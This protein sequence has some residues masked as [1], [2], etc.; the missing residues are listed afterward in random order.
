MAIQV[1]KNEV[2]NKIAAGEVVERASSVVKE[3][4]ENSL[5]AGATQITVEITGGGLA[6]I[7]ITDNGCGIL[8]DEIQLAFE[9]HATSKIT[10]FEDLSLS[11]SLGFRGEALPSIASVS[12]VDVISFNTSESS[13]VYAELENGLIVKKQKQ[14]RSQGTTI[15]V[16]NLFRNVPARLKFIKSKTTENSHIA[17]VVS[18][19]A[20]AY[21][22]VRFSLFIDGRDSLKTPGTGILST[23]SMLY[24]VQRLLPVCCD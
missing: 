5:D 3:L 14:A 12:D 17:N 24:T 9:R 11:H 2:I 19:Y 10:S 16:K 7:R 21:P 18:Q 15:S 6:L 20:L 22:E 23:V 1:L 13:G 4:V 8:S